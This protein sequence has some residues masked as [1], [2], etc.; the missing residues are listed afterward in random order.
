MEKV[1][2]A[3]LL[4]SLNLLAAPVGAIKDTSTTPID[5]TY[6]GAANE[7]IAGSSN[8]LGGVI[9]VNPTTTGL[10][11]CVFSLSVGDCE[12]D[13]YIPA[14]SFRAKRSNYIRGL[15][16]RAET[17]TISADGVIEGTGE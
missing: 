15:W 11:A 12:D 4:F 1:I 17:G 8:P 10:Y 6:A 14:G 2:V 16:L 7:F 13:M 9:V 3:L 5:N